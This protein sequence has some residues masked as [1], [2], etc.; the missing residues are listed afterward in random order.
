MFPIDIEILMFLH[1]I[2]TFLKIF[3]VS[4]FTTY[5]TSG[6]NDVSKNYKIFFIW[7][8]VRLLFI[9][10]VRLMFIKKYFEIVN[11]HIM[12]RYFKGT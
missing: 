8:T 3:I 7:E 11:D 5:S 2:C 1:T 12:V 10:T 4:S 9:E 6:S